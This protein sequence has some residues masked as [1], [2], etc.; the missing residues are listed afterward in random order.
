[1]IDFLLKPWPWYTGG[2]LIAF[3]LFLLYYFGKSFGVSSNLD[4][5]CSIAGADKIS[6]YFK[7]NINTK[8]WSLFFV[9]GVVV[10]GFLAH[11]YL[12]DNSFINLNPK[13][14]N[15]LSELGFTNIGINYLPQEIFGLENLN[16]VKGFLILLGAG[17][18]IGFGTRYAGGCT[19]GH[20]I[21]GLSNLQVP[22][23]VATIGFFIGG[24]VMTWLLIPIIF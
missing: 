8:S 10:G 22:S 14:I 18:L 20:A 7:I 16:T 17:F 3:V 2:P 12:S 6:D 13:T 19:S 24:L 9:L 15:E 4:Y 21:T 1:M 5:L 11:F 23:L